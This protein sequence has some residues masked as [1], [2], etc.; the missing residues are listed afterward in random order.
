MTKKQQVGIKMDVRSAA[1]VRQVL[2]EAQKGYG[3]QHVPE[4]IH[5]IRT[6]IKNIDD[7]LTTILGQTLSDS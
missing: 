4:R 3:Y 2:F 7:E 5:N 1:A 6:V